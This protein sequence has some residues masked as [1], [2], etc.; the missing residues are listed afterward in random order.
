MVTLQQLK[1]ILANRVQRL[2]EAQLS[3]D[4]KTGRGGSHQQGN[5]QSA[6][7][8]TEQCYTGKTLPRM[9]AF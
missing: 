4:R 9:Q 7:K 3:D 1:N 6:G 8:R 2:S 5:H